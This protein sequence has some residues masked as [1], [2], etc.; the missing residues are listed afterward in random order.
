M[1]R[2]TQIHLSS[3]GLIRVCT[4]KTAKGTYFRPIIKLAPLPINENEDINDLIQ[5]MNSES[6]TVTMLPL[7]L[8]ESNPTEKF[9]ALKHFLSKSSKFNIIIEGNIGAG[10]TTLLKHL[11]QLGTDQILT[12]REPLD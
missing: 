12:F 4:V 3:D 10:K 7:I 5:P 8:R 2:I 1:G 9:T 11:E 6:S